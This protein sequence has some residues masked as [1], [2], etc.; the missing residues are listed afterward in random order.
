V[1][2]RWSVPSARQR[3]SR[4]K[5]LKTREDSLWDKSAERDTSGATAMNHGM[6]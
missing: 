4:R 6:R 5:Q 3:G 1:S 2:E